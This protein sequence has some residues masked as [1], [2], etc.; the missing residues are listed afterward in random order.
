VLGEGSWGVV[1]LASRAMAP[2]L[3]EDSTAPHMVA[4]KR[5]KPSPVP[6]EGVNFTAL[7]EIKYLRELRHENIIDVSITTE[8]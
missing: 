6:K 1:Y 7:R 3:K 5:I 8:A 2:G 4:I